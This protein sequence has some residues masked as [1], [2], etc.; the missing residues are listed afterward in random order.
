MQ[1]TRSLTLD[2]YRFWG[3]TVA[4]ILFAPAFLFSA[5]ETQTPSDTL[6][7]VRQTGTLKLGY[8]ADAGPFSYRDETG[9][10]AGYA[11]SLCQ[12]I[13]NDLKTEMGVPN[14]DVEFVLVTGTDRFDAITQGRVDLLCGPSVE[15]FARRKEVSFSIPIFPAGLAALVRTDAPAQIREV[16]ASH[17]PPYR[18]LWRASIGLALQHRTFSAVTN[19]TALNWLT[20]KRDEFKIDARIVPVE[21]HDQGVQRVLNRTSDVLFGERSILLDAKKRNAAGQDLVVLDRLF[22]Y[23]PLSF[24][25]ARG[26]EDLRLLVD[27]SLSRLSRSGETQNHYRRFF[28]EPDEN[29]LTFFR[30]NT[31]AD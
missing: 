13:A 21:S 14:L 6:A 24:A 29:A 17:P 28:G 1:T 27:Q 19:T 30:L 16:L 3:M 9:K 23:E 12:Q 31:V 8:Y 2:G 22:T 11:I 15:T 18:P 5:D 26:N 10:P 7:R 4:F 20:S 25:L